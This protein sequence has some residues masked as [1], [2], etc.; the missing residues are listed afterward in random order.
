MNYYFAIDVGGTSTKGGIIDENNSLLC[1]DSIKTDVSPENNFL[2]G[3]ILDLIKKL[4]LKSG[5]SIKCASGLGIGLPGQVDPQK[6]EIC[7]SNNL[8]IYNYKIIDEIKKEIDIPIKIAND[9]NLATLAEYKLGSA[10]NLKNFIMLT[11]GTGIGGDFFIDG[12]PYSLLSPFSGEVGHIK[13]ST[14]TRKKCACGQHGC[15]ETYA[16][17]RALVEQTRKAMQKNK[18]SKMWQNYNEKSVNGKT[19][20]EYLNTDKTARAIFEKYIKYLGD[21][22]VSLV[23]LFMPQAVIIGGSISNQK[24]KLTQ[25]LSDYVNSRHYAKNMPDCKIKILPA[26]L[27]ADAGIF[28]AKNLF[29]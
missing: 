6:G 1:K 2:A 18:D 13:I 12:K 28:G 3:C 14:G 15:F 20:F 11:L 5:L 16:S 29:D 22:I 9:A 19:V 8:G 4:E 21:G 27:G 10:K 17:T 24:E 25:P 7:V 26:I 23:N